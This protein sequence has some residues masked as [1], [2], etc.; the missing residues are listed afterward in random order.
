MEKK[1][2]ITYRT[3]HILNVHEHIDGGFFWNKYSAFPYM[4]CEWGCEYCYCRG[5]KYNPYT[6]EDKDPDIKRFEDPFSQY[7]KIK[8]DAPS[9]LRKALENNPVDLIYIS[10]YQPIERSYRY[11]R[12]MLE[13]CLEERF[14][15]FINEKSDLP[16]EDLDVLKRISEETHL[17]VGWSI[18]F[19]EDDE[20]K[21]AFEPRA[22]SIQSRFE[23]ME[24]LADED[25]PTGT[26]MM[27]VL[28][29]VTDE[30]EYIEKIVKKT[31]RHGGKYVLEGGLTLQGE[32]KTHL[33]KALERYEPDLV[34]RYDKLF[35]SEDEMREHMSRV[36]ELV[37]R[38]CEMYDLLD[39]IPRPIGHFP[40][41]IRTNKKVAGKL[42]L[43][44]RESRFSGEARHR[45]WAYRKAAASIDELEEDIKDIYEK[46]GLDGLMDIQ[47]VGEKIGA[48]IVER[49]LEK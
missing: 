10:G 35:A 29:F 27:P 5:E 47:Y 19:A 9:L 16:L 3:A 12:K 21:R 28:P 14:P 41:K 18:S 11:T 31:K 37:Q 43:M 44:A 33:Y 23:A 6:D 36:H 46:E 40:K 15:V 13:V 24:E 42:F 39:H 1:E 30:D 8:E 38:Y 48:K 2:Y 4:G 22:P 49:F 34:E 20:K 7:I 26:V 17:N 45:E 25:I 32:T